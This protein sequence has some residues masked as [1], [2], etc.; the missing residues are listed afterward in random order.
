M[1]RD[2]N[3][4]LIV[5]DDQFLQELCAAKFD[6]EGFVVKTA[7]SGKECFKQLEKEKSNIILLDILLPDTSGFDVLKKLKGNDEYRDIPVIFLTNLSQR[8][9]IEKGVELGAEYYFIKAHCTPSE[10]V[11]RVKEILNK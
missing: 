7:I 6:Q 5:E 9:D 11:K 4:I 1:D 2:K 3:K 10:V 8:S